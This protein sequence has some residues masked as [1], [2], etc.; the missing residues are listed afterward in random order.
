MTDGGKLRQHRNITTTIELRITPP[1]YCDSALRATWRGKAYQKTA[2][3]NLVF[4][5]I[6]AKEVVRGISS[7]ASRVSFPLKRV[8]TQ[9]WAPNGFGLF[10]TANRTSRKAVSD[11]RC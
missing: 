6:T 1:H 10:M 5:K 9:E 11:L 2:C 3:S 4:D 7:G 8:T